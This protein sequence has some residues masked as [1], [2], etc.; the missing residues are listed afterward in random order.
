MQKRGWPLLERPVPIGRLVAVFSALIVATAAAPAAQ[1]AVDVSST[2]DPG[3]ATNGTVDAVARS[4]STIYLGGS[5][6]LVAQQTGP[7][8][9]TGAGTGGLSA[10]VPQVSGGSVS[11][12]A[13]DGAGGFFIGG[14]FTAIDGIPRDY[15]AHILA[16]GELDTGWAPDATSSV[17]AL[18]LLGGTLYV[19]GQVDGG[20]NN[21]YA[22]N[23]DSGSLL[24][25]WSPAVNGPVNGIL[26]TTT[27]IYIGGSFTSPRSYLAAFDPSTGALQ[28]WNPSANGWAV[29]TAIDPA[30]GDVYVRGSFDHLGGVAWE[31]VAKVSGGS[32]ALDT[33]WSP[34]ITA[35]NAVGA[36]VQAGSTVYLAGGSGHSI[37]G[38]DST[39]GTPTGW[40][41]DLDGSIAQMAIAGS[42]LYVVGSFDTAGDASRNNAAAFDLTTGDVAGW[43]PS[44]LGGVATVAV[45]SDG[46]QVAVGGGFAGVGA[47]PRQN[48]AAEDALTGQLTAWNPA[49]RNQVD[50]LAVNGNQVWVDGEFDGYGVIGGDS[51]AFRGGLAAVDATT[52]ALL[53]IYPGDWLA[54]G[55]IS[56]LAMAN[57][58]L[59][60]IGAFA[61]TVGANAVYRDQL[62]AINPADGTVVEGFD[63][64]ALT[65]GSFS[66]LAVSGSTVYV[67]GDFK[68]GS[69]STTHYAAAFDANSGALLPWDPTP[70]NWVYAIAATPG[71]V[72][73]GGIFTNVDGSARSAAAAVDSASGALLAWNPQVTY[74]GS[75]GV[76][77]GIATSG[78]NVYVAGIF[79]AAQGQS[80]NGLVAVDSTT[81]KP[82]VWNPDTYV[83]NVRPLAGD[84]AGG[85]VV[86]GLGAFGVPP[87]MVVAPTVSGGGVSGSP[88]TCTQGQWSGTQP[89]SYLLQWLRDGSAIQDATGTSYTPVS[90]DVGHQIACRVTADDLAGSAHADS[91]AVTVTAAAGGSG[92]QSS[93]GGPQAGAA[94]KPETTTHT[95]I[96]DN[97]KI[98]LVLPAAGICLAPKAGLSARFS[99]A[100]IKGSKLAKLTF[101]QAAFY[102]DRGVKHLS[103]HPGTVHGKHKQ[104][105]VTTYLPNATVKKAS[106]TERLKLAGLKPGGHTLKLVLTYTEKATKT[107]GHAKR[108]RSTVAKT[109]T[110]S[111]A[112][113]IKI[114]SA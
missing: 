49:P 7:L 74:N 31:S 61:T 82:S 54:A 66:A 114:C 23:A 72:Y 88:L 76:V 84:G 60:M 90:G 42:T 65:S 36:V 105:T 87:A 73:L 81:G 99:S 29:P 96:F 77:E 70:D 109:V 89:Q 64:T 2:A 101:K 17:G 22:L 52:G 16:D 95:V 111:L 8:A 5:F 86:G 43:N 44:V 71:A 21:V 106:F 46:S 26:A 83:G 59:Y 13:A 9:L 28:S 93:S 80:D 20:S 79:N 55:G 34:G 19:G 98:T 33:A 45:S 68:E 107:G 56:Q 57:G 38:F 6:S 3:I 100:P 37:E 14:S 69:S 113:P 110:K 4:D 78:N 47:V 104:T 102:L 112:T 75:P 10:A 62:A 30:T 35:N 27:S 25:N 11:A 15:I 39:T 94:G 103:K 41:A 12:V 63:P 24:G 85:V 97:Q 50:A 92:G 40:H 1:A 32:G 51:T 48:A 58:E 108:T 91:A 53:P 67:G 18:A